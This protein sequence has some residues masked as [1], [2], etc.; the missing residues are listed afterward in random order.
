MPWVDGDVFALDAPAYV[1]AVWGNKDGAIWA[2]GEPLEI[3]GPQGVGKTTLIQRLLCA[4]LDIGGKSVLGFPVTPDPDR[5]VIYMAADRPSQ[6]ARS[7]RRMVD[8]S[9]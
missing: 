2:E 8:E 3:V 1:P 7:I 6:Q 9:N 5:R 4:R